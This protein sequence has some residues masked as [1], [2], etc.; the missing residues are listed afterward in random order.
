M[1][2]SYEHY[3]F[4][5][6]SAWNLVIMVWITWGLDPA[7]LVA[8]IGYQGMRSYVIA[9]NSTLRM[10]EE[11]KWVANLG[12]VRNTREIFEG[13]MPALVPYFGGIAQLVVANGC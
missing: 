5:K 3:R 7:H 6:F 1:L 9:P 8:K 11:I 13:P 10:W 12:H 4:I 2:K